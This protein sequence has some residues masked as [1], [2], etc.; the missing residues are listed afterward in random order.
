MK[1]LIL[2]IVLSLLLPAATFAADKN[3]ETVPDLENTLYLDLK[4]GRVTIELFH[5]DAPQTVARIKELTRAGFYDGLKFHRVIT[6]FMAQTGDPTGTGM[7][8]SDLPDLPDEIAPANPNYHYRGYLSMANAGPGTGNSQFFIMF[9]DAQ[10]SQLEYLNTHHSVWGKVI[11]GMKHVDKI[12]KSIG[13]GTQFD[14][15]PDVIV[16]MQI[17]ADAQ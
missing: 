7:G 3:K 1:S 4:D 6:D 14:G 9:E 8:S 17:A 15:E 12:K 10:G 5:E 2:T 16:R 11:D 13:D